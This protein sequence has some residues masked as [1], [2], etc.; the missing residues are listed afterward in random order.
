M[1][2][3]FAQLLTCAALAGCASAPSPR[4][5]Q[6]EAAVLQSGSETA[7]VTVAERI[8]RIEN[9]L[10]PPVSERGQ[11]QVTLSLSAQMR[12]YRT[13]AVSVA[14]INNGRIE[15]ARAWGVREAGRAGAADADTLFAAGSIS[16]PV[17]AMAALRMVQ[18]GRLDLGSNVNDRLRSWHVPENEFTTHEKVTLRR[19]LNHTSGLGL[20]SGD[21]RPETGPLPSLPEALSGAG[22]GDAAVVQFVPGARQQYSS[23]GFSVVQLLVSDVS[24]RP[25]DEAMRELVF[26]PLGMQRSRY[27]QRPLYGADPNVARGHN[28]VT[29]GT[30]DPS[31]PTSPALAAAGLWTT[32]TD[33]ARFIVALQRARA[34][35]EGFVLSRENAEL[36]LTPSRGIWSLGL[37]VDTRGRTPRFWHDG[38]VPGFLSY[39]VAYNWNGQ[40]AVVMVNQDAYNG[41][42]IAAEIM[43]GIAREYGWTD[44]GPLERTAIAA[45]PARF[46]DYVGSYEIDAGYPVTI[47]ARGGRLYLIWA[48]GGTYEMYRSG[49]EEFFIAR[50]GAPTFTFVRDATG[51]V[52][53]VTRRLGGGADNGARTPL[54][55]PAQGSRSFRL[56]GHED[57]LV[58]SLIGDFNGWR[59][60]ANVCARERAGWLCRA[61]L[62]PGRN[63]Y[64][65][66]VDNQP[67]L[68]PANP[69][70]ARNAEG[71]EASVASPPR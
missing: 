29:G 60:Q 37:Q 3:R 64:L 7:T 45:D 15:W 54:P 31:L 40:G 56:A 30:V 16:K 51:R 39:M 59:R 50:D 9:G 4:T 32:P 65:F 41:L 28:S 58:V 49:E 26:A 22:R 13:P 24:G 57:A 34:G 52:T 35:E 44:F 69:A 43:Y 62:S 8:A 47:V 6:V 48:L 11:P 63:L 20:F 18:E 68:D 17:A 1:P 71:D 12:R 67:L 46:D 27:S 14:V 70:R 61:D 53:G 21:G 23:A 5:P 55:A 42:K 36:M 19:L 66:A 25:F 33:L 38:S 2:V 10:V